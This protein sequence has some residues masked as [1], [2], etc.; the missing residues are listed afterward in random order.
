MS[1][2]LVLYEELQCCLSVREISADLRKNERNQLSDAQFVAGIATN[3]A[4]PLAVSMIA[5]RFHINPLVACVIC[6]AVTPY[7]KSLAQSVVK[8]GPAD[9]ST[10]GARRAGAACSGL[11]CSSRIKRMASAFDQ[12]KTCRQAAMAMMAAMDLD[13]ERIRCDVKGIKNDRPDDDQWTARLTLSCVQ[14]A[15]T[16]SPQPAAYKC[17]IVRKKLKK[18]AWK[19]SAFKSHLNKPK[20]LP[21]IALQYKT[22]LHARN[23]A[24]GGGKRPCLTLNQLRKRIADPTRDAAIA[25][26]PMSYKDYF[27]EFVKGFGSSGQT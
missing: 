13:S 12:L 20:R 2:I 17:V 16:E 21:D 23:A 19:K 24:K 14:S 7:A 27:Q 9:I 25:Y 6:D 8:Q 3:F 10:N 4:V 18:S 15:V 26:V 22:P 11:P 1:T 5:K